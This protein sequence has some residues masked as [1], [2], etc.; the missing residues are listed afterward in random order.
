[1]TG[2]PIIDIAPLLAGSP[3]DAARVA[4]EIGAACRNIGFFYI[5]GHGVPD[6]LMNDVYALARRFFAQPQEKKDA[7]RIGFD[8]RGY[9]GLDTEQLN[10]A[11][12][13]DAK[14]AINLARADAVDAATLG[15][16]PA[17]FPAFGPVMHDYDA[18]MR[19]LCERLHGAFA[20]D[21]GLASDY[22]AGMIDRPMAVLRLLHYPPVD[23][24]DGA[25]VGAGAHTDYGN[26]TILS[27]DGTGGLEV[28]TRTDDWIAAPPVEGSFICNIGDCLMRWS[29][30]VYT[31]TPHRVI[32]PAGRDRYSVA[33]F[34][35]VNSDALVQ[36]LPG[37]CDVDHPARYPPILAGDYLKSRL[38]ATYSFRLS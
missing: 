14:E 19:A 10:A 7:V 6:A 5:V 4:G 13:P 9:A 12:A 17:D 24:A 32:S 26:I 3:A 1:M 22:F 15:P 29:N 16:I 2:V 34:F 28:R 27:Q 38:D 20:M 33:F 30:E 25:R 8:N 31:S 21:L 37:C 36:C 35:D 11:E 18:R 23:R